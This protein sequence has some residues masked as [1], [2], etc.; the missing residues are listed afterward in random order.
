LIHWKRGADHSE[1]HVMDTDTIRWYENFG[2]RRKALGRIYPTYLIG[3]IL[4]WATIAGLFCGTLTLLSWFSGNEQWF[5]PRGVIVISVGLFGGAILR[6]LV[7][8]LLREVNVSRSGIL[9]HHTGWTRRRWP[10]SRTS[11]RIESV[12][13]TL[14]RVEFHIMA[15][16]PYRVVVGAP[17]DLA[18]RIAAT[19]S[20]V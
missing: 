2:M 16:R 1:R 17:K 6:L 9:I 10:A 7:E 19:L 15:R 18:K 4:M 5:G 20:A 11:V 12:D 8:F 3:A 14:A 13:S